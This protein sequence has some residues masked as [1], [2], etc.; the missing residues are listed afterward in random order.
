MKCL[1][2][3][4]AC[5]IIVACAKAPEFSFETITFDQA[6]EKAVAENKQVLLDFYSPT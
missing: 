4:F 6:L 1:F 2:A 3:I 5:A